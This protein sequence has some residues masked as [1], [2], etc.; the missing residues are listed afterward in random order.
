MIMFDLLFCNN[1][2]VVD[3][4]HQWTFCSLYCIK[5]RVDYLMPGHSFQ[6]VYARPTDL[7]D[8]N[9]DHRTISGNFVFI[10]PSAA[11]ALDSET[12]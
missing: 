9:S 7:L 8:L 11:R 4:E 3:G 5:R 2:E 1:D 12:A 10:T 6:C